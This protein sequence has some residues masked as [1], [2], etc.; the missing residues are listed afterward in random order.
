MLTI[1]ALN[2][3]GANTDEGLGRCFDNEAFY[4]RLVGA[5]PDEK[6]FDTLK[7]ALDE[8]N[9]DAAFEAAHALKGVLTNLSLTPLAEPAIEITENLRPRKEMDYGPLLER[10]LAKRDELK[11]LCE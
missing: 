9:L 7:N 8:N 4:L 3:F 11:K 10:L 6:H 1:D 2:S 5:V